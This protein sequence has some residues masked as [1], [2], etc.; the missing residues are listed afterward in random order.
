MLIASAGVVAAAICVAAVVLF[1]GGEEEEPPARLRLEEESRAATARARGRAG[2]GEAVQAREKAPPVSVPMRVEEIEPVEGALVEVRFK[3]LAGFIRSLR[4]LGD[5]IAPGLGGRVLAIIEANLRGRVE[6][7]LEEGPALLVAR[8][9]TKTS[10]PAAF[11]VPVKSSDA[12][13]ATLETP[14]GR[15][16]G[17]EGGIVKFIRFG[18]AG[19]DDLEVFARITGGRAVVSPDRGLL[20]ELSGELAPPEAD[21]WARIDPRGLGEAYGKEFPR[22]LGG[23]LRA[24]PGLARGPLRRALAV[25]RLVLRN[26]DDLIVALRIEEKELGCVSGSR[27]VE[28][29][30]LEKAL[31]ALVPLGRPDELRWLPEDCSVTCA[32][33]IDGERLNGVLA[34]FRGEEAAAAKAPR[35][36][37][38]RAS[39]VAVC[40]GPGGKIAMLAA[41][42]AEDGEKVRRLLERAFSREIPVPGVGTMTLSYA[43]GARKVGDPAANN[44]TATIDNS[45]SRIGGSL[46][47]A[48]Q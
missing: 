43:R 13:L 23:V 30:L 32:L 17:T 21:V 44:M 18:A 6:D 5:E 39:T 31:G 9:V 10:F 36:G 26:L 28:G 16:E 33:G 2:Q 40:F 1:V 8:K 38:A 41:M 3:N 37:P 35:G 12:F 7:L 20:R 47:R 25:T 15:I 22:L 27:A 42:R 24:V 14:I 48:R 19:G 4:E 46:W 11:S 45:A 29:S 34:A